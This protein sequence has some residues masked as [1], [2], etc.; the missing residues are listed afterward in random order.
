MN[1]DILKD[2]IDMSIAQC[3]KLIDS[4]M[5]EDK[6]REFVAEQTARIWHKEDPCPKT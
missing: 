3:L 1:E 2:L 4:G 5:D 6:A